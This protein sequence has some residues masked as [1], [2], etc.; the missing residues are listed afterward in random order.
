MSSSLR[1]RSPIITCYLLRYTPIV[2]GEGNWPEMGA[3]LVKFESSLEQT[4]GW[5]LDSDHRATNVFARLRVDYCYSLIGGHL[6]KGDSNKP[7]W[8][9]TTKVNACI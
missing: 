2:R 4:R 6:S 8:A 3:T 7:P 5:S 9:F 1:R